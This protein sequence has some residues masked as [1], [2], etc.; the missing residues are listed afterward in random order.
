MDGQRRGRPSTSANPVQ[1]IDAA[2]QEAR[3]VD[4]AQ[5][6]LRFNLT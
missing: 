2:V 1:N 4:I 6:E 5:L 3:R